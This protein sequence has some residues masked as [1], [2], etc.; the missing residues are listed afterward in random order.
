MGCVVDGQSAYWSMKDVLPVLASP[1]INQ[2]EVKVAETPGPLSNCHQI[3]GTWQGRVACVVLVVLSIW[4]LAWLGSGR[5]RLGIVDEF[6][7]SQCGG[8]EAGVHC[9]VRFHCNEQS[10]TCREVTLFATWQMASA[11]D[12]AVSHGNGSTWGHE[13]RINRDLCFPSANCASTNAAVSQW[14]RPV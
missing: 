3:R 7:P 6:L 11:V 4:G 12:A 2:V 1:S 5:P 9:P 14:P 13:I 10:C 8:S